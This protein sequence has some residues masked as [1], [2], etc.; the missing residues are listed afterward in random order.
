VEQPFD[1]ARLEIDDEDSGFPPA[2]PASFSPRPSGRPS[3]D[4]EHGFF[5]AKQASLA[6][7]FPSLPAPPA[8]VVSPERLHFAKLLFAT[9][10]GAIALF[11]GYALL[12]HVH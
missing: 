4:F 6:P 12:H 2:E 11:L 7:A 1:R 5:A 10:F 8:R 9:L 3:T